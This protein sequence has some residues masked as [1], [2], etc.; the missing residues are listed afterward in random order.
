MKTKFRAYYP[1]AADPDEV[2]VS[3]K[4]KMHKGSPWETKYTMV[5]KDD[6][7]YDGWKKQ[8][9]TFLNDSNCDWHIDTGE[10]TLTLNP[11]E[12]AVLRKFIMHYNKYPDRKIE[13]LI[14]EEQ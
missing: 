1:L 10:Q 11:C 12:F 7:M 5:V 8:K 3:V 14:M 9:Y 2:K 4:S 6:N 13:K